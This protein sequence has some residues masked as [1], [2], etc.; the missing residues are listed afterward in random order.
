[1]HVLV[2]VEKNTKHVMEKMP[3]NKYIDHTILKPTCLVADIEKLCAEAKL[4]MN[5]ETG[6]NTR[7]RPQEDGL[8]GDREE[9]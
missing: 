5:L 1:M 4:M 3:L 7:S 9:S 2:E 8:G 6:S